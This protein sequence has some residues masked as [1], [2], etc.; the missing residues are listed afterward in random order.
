MLWLTG[1][2]ALIMWESEAQKA[3]FW[4]AWFLDLPVWVTPTFL[5]LALSRTYVTYWPRARLRDVLMVMFW[6][7]TGLLF[8][9]GL[10]LIIDPAAGSQWAL[11]TLLIAGISHPVMMVSRLFYRCID[12]LVLWIRRQA[13][14]SSIT[15]RVL[16]Y[17]AG[18]RAQ[19]FLKDY[20][21]KNSTLNDPRVIPG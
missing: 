11:R 19:L 21:A 7:Q 5:L 13:D 17:G 8:S 12:E 4:R 20:A 10:A 6:L 1:S 2:L 14:A 3:G 16:L 18:M 15:E 9:L